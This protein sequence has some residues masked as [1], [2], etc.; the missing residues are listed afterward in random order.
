M[1]SVSRIKGSC[2]R[3]EILKCQQ[4]LL[5]YIHNILKLV[6]LDY[7]AFYKVILFEIIIHQIN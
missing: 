1:V 2:K 6:L 4:I 5:F 7:K 3:A